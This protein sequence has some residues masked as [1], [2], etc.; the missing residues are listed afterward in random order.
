MDA[1]DDDSWVSTV[2]LSNQRLREIAHAA[3]DPIWKDG[4]TSRANA[5][6]LLAEALGVSEP[7]AHMKEMGQELLLRVPPVAEELRNRLLGTA[8]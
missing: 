3:F 2:P 6:R 4:L 7:E 5:Y 1:I 8:S